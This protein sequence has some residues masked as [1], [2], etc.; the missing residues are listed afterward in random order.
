MEKIIYGL[1]ESEFGEIIIAR[2]DKGLCWL[3]FMVQGYKGDG[4]NRLRSFYP[5]SECIR[6]DAQTLP[7]FKKTMQA[8]TSGQSRGWSWICEAVLSNAPCG[9]HFWIFRADNSA[10]I[11]IL[12]PPSAARKPCAPWPAPWEKIRCP[13]LCR[14]TGSCAKTAGWV[15]T[16]G[17]LS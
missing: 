17:E 12:P 3:G 15:I 9:T 10:P 6:D 7:L 11:A 14:A 2:S 5:E 13:C 16:A 4:L 8:W 1:H